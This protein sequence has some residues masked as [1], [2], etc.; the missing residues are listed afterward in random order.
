MRQLLA[1]V[2]LALSGT[3]SAQASNAPAPAPAMVLKAAHLFDGRDGRLQSPG[4]L[5]VSNGRIVGVGAEAQVPAGARVVDL[6]DATLLP[7][8]IDA[9]VHLTGDHV[10][11]WAQGFYEGMMRPAVEQSFHA[12][13]NAKL[14]LEAGFTSVRNV[15]SSDFIDVALRNAIDE[16][17]VEG[18]RVVAAGNAIGSTGGHCDASPFPPEH[19]PQVGR[20]RACAMARRNAGRPCAC[21]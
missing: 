21:R 8:F 12:E 18:P 19:V 14:T 15:G 5:V 11:D 1:I 20:C 2:L 13:R 6:G 16:G 7:G 4:L 9:H 17:L 3:G 10:D